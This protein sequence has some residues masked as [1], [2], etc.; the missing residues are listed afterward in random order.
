MLANESG[1]LFTM[2]TNQK[3]IMPLNKQINFT[4]ITR[5]YVKGSIV[6]WSDFDYRFSYINEFDL[7]SKQY[8]TR[9]SRFYHLFPRIAL[10][11]VGNK[12]IYRSSTIE[13]NEIKQLIF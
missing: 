4:D 11:P 8:K 5:W 7:Q 9:K 13:N 1:W 10:S 3:T 2:M 6:F 12:F